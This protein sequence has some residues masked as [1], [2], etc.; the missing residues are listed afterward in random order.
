MERLQASSMS[1]ALWI[2]LGKAQQKFSGRPL[3]V[4]GFVT[5]MPILCAVGGRKDFA[6]GTDG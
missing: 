6:F 1:G 5:E 4:T 2:T 3:H